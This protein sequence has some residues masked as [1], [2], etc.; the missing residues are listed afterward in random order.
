MPLIL[1]KLFLLRKE[2]MLIDVLGAKVLVEVLV[3]PIHEQFSRLEDVISIS[4]LKSH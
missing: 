1:T 2:L 3:E 4:H